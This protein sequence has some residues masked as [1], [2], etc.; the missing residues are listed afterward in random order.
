MTLLIFDIDGTLT[1]TKGVDDHCF[2][3]A[4]Q[5]EY[6]VELH[7]I[8]WANFKNITDLGQDGH[9]RQLGVEP[10]LKDFRNKEILTMILNQ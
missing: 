6:A 10:I 2:M 1:D 4:F 5:D 9:L 8:D 7:N 3:S